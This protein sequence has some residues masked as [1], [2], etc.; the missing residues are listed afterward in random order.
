[1]SLNGFSFGDLHSSPLDV[2]VEDGAVDAALKRE[3]SSVVDAVFAFEAPLLLCTISNQAR[4]EVDI[5]EG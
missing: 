3:E 2:S 4:E 1:M 5:S